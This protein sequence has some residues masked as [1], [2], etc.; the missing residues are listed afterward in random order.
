M[1]KEF[2]IQ[3]IVPKLGFKITHKNMSL[4]ELGRFEKYG[5]KF[6]FDVYLETYGCNLQR[7]FVWTLQQKQEFI[8]SLIKNVNIPQVAIIIYSEENEESHSIYKVIDGKQRLSTVMSFL[9]DEFPITVDD[10][11]YLFSELPKDIKFM[12]EHYSPTAQ[13]AYS[14]YDDK[15][16]DDDLIKWFNLLNFAGTEQEKSHKDKLNSLINK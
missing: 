9:K 1:K 11:D 2:N 8:F 4:P 10:E 6:D 15:I 16:S 5:Y 3:A 12:I 14:Y 7:D 13:I